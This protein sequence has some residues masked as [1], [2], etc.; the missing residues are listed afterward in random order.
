MST[1]NATTPA[2]MLAAAGQAEPSGALGVI[3]TADADAA[4]DALEQEMA[5]RPPL[6][7]PLV[8]RFTPGL[9][10]REIFMP[11]DSLITSKIHKTEHPFVV[12][13]G[14][15]LVWIDGIGWQLIEAPYTGITKPG[16]RRVLLILEDT[17]WTTFHPIAPEEHD[18]LAAIEARIIEPRDEHLK[19][20]PL[21]SADELAALNGDTPCLG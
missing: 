15:C 11:A 19:L 21:P 10:V 12:S 13:K 5:K 16:T 17:V 14:R 8:H 4:V 3:R 7:C 9:Y 18:N 20:P 6:D 2:M 1:M